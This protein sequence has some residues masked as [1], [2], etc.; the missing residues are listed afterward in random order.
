MS[1]V[2]NAVVIGGIAVAAATMAAAPAQA[3]PQGRVDPG[4]AIGWYSNDHGTGCSYSMTVPVNSSGLVSFYERGDSGAPVLIGRDR[5]V[6]VNASVTWWPRHTG[7]RHLYAVQN[8]ERSTP[9]SVVVTRSMLGGGGLCV[10]G[11]R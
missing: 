11:P 9:T 10:A 1:R 8:G 2:K 3:A 6:G 4:V 5:A 7:R